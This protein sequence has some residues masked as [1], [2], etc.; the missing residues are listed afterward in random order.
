MPGIRIISALVSGFILLSKRVADISHD[1]NKRLKWVDYYESH[2]RNA[3]QTCRHFNISPDT[4]YRWKKRYR[5][6]DVKSLE[7]RSHRP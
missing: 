6:G 5:P 2:R 4:F 7:E 3:R 1:A